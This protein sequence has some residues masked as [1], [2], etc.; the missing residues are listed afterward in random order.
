M[1]H[2]IDFSGSD[3][4]QNPQYPDV[5]ENPLTNDEFKAFIKANDDKMNDLEIKFDQFQIQCEQMQDDHLNQ[6]RNF[7]QNFQNG[8]PGEDKEHEATTDTELVSTEDIQPL[9]VQEPPQNSDMHQIIEECCVEASEEQKQK[10]EDTM[11]DLVQICHHKQFLC[12]HDDVDDLMESALDSKLLLINSINSQRLDKKEQESKNVEEQLA[13]R[14]NHAEKSLQNFRVI[15]KN[16]ISL[17]SSQISLVHAVAPI[18]STKVTEHLLSMGYEHLNITPETESDE[19]TES[20]AK[21]LLPIPSKCEVALEDKRECDLLIFE[22]SPVCNSDTFSDS[23]IDDDIS[24]YDDDF[25]DI[26]YVEALLLDPEIV[27]VEEENVVQQEEEEV[28]LEEI[29]QVQD[30]VLREKLFSITRLISNIESLK[31]NSTPDHVLNSFESNNSLLDNFS[32]EFGTFCDHSEETRSGNTT[33]ANYSL[34]EYDLFCFEIEPDQERNRFSNDP[35]L[36]ETDLFLSDDSI[37]PGIENV[38]DDPEGD[39]RFLEELLIDDS[40]LSHELYDDNNPS[41]S[42]PPPEPPDVES[43]FDLKPD[44]IAKEISDKLNKDKC[45]DPGREINVS[46]KIEDDDYFPFMFVIRIFLPYL[47]L[48]EI[49]PLFLSAESEDT[50]FDPGISD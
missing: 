33:H 48:P 39:V 3:Q 38:A 6:M 40:I 8:P 20:N 25:E 9:P 1:D 26:E 49:S 15:H 27:S 29:S 16:S 45:F 31:D 11:L 24:V 47:I 28:D 14:R 46:T 23:K 12:I 43:F 17:N 35:L 32:P 50:I 4:I 19:V 42:L 13:E 36:E 37:P 18:L 7:I 21:N 41:I 2:N 22:N 10:M 44:V 30:V 34:P 5:Q